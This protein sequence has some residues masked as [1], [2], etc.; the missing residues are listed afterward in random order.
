MF[1]F[2]SSVIL[3][4]PRR[5]NSVTPPFEASLLDRKWPPGWEIHLDDPHQKET[6]PGRASI[7]A[8]VVRR[9]CRVSGGSA[10][11]LEL[12]AHE[13]V[14]PPLSMFQYVATFC[15]RL[16]AQLFVLSMRIGGHNICM[17]SQRHSMITVAGARWDAGFILVV[18]KPLG[19]NAMASKLK[20]ITSVWKKKKITS[21]VCIGCFTVFAVGVT[22][23]TFHNK[24]FIRAWTFYVWIISFLTTGSLIVWIITIHNWTSS[25]ALVSV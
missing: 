7:L 19:C 17:T 1:L 2:P 5:H 9:N 25:I 20:C 15:D 21:V 8:T 4:I 16:D 22:M 24:A 18:R 3:T 6:A 12:N 14:L 10:L 13:E 23:V 11:L